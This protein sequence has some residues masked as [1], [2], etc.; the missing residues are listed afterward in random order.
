MGM[1]CTLIANIRPLLIGACPL[2]GDHKEVVR[3][4]ERD[5]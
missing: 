1:Q 2:V 4:N 3:R 5:N